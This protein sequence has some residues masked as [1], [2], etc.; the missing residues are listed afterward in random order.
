VKRALL[1][2]SLSAVACGSDFDPGSRIVGT[3]VIAVRADKPYAAPGEQVNIEAIAYDTL[4]RPLQWG[5]TTCVDPRSTTV[6]GC[7]AK[8]LE[9]AQKTPPSFAI[10]DGKNTFALTIPSDALS[11]LP[12]EARGSAYV[13]ALIVTCPGKIQ[14]QN[15]EVPIACID[16]SGRS[17]RLDEFEIGVK[18]IFVREKDRNANPKIDSITW[19][20]AAWAEGDVKE[21][22]PCP[23]RDE[24]RYDRCDGEKHTIAATPTADSYESGTDERG[25]TFAEQVIAQYYATEGLFE[26]DVRIGNL[27]STG[28]VARAGASGTTVTIWF[29]LRDDRGGLAWT[30]RSVKVR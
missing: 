4:G 21:V 27:P 8:V 3:R 6:T 2:L 5:W 9:D 1:I 19:D 29:V 28:G 22:T 16:A 10:G 12:A 11:R 26:Y 13:G 25:D 24:N 17:L 15:A 23:S 18:R 30:S 20:G 7:L 14:L